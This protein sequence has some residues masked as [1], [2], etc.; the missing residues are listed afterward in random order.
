MSDIALKNIAAYAIRYN[1]RIAERLGFGIHGTWFSRL[2]T[3]PILR[4]GL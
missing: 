1:L 4:G 3:A 2:V